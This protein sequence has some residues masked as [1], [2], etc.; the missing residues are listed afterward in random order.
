MKNVF[1]LIPIILIYNSCLLLPRNATTAD[2]LPRETD[3]PG[4]VI[5][6]RARIEGEKKTVQISPLYGE[7][8]PAEM[9]A[10]EYEYLSDRSKMVRV[11]LI[12]LRSTLDAFGLYSRMRGLEV[13]ALSPED[14]A[15]SLSNGIFSRTGKYCFR[16]SGSGL[17]DQDAGVPELFRGVVMQNLKAHAG[18]EPLPDHLFLFS[19]KRST[20]GIVYYKKGVDTLPGLNG[21]SIIRRL[22]GGKQYDI[23]YARF[24]TAL[25]AEQEFQKLLK[26]GGDA[27][28]L[29]RIGNLQPAIRIVGA[30]E[31]IF[32]S[33]H[34]QWI[35]GVMNADTMGE[36]NRIFIY[37]Y[38]EIKK[39][40]GANQ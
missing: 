4:W 35:F 21:L 9:S 37:L 14:T 2:F 19:E 24:N 18:G 26:A 27:F 34:K 17:G 13:A 11:E 3:V 28:I 31:H 30:G 20:A 29:S 22:L 23:A 33:H 8:D 36:G 38:G 39:K 15:C 7:Y 6:G 10:A 25:D 32:I 12:K 5:T 16:V 40:V 1:Y